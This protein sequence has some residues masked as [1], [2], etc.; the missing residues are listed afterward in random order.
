MRPLVL[1]ERWAV[2]EWA[3]GCVI[4]DRHTGDTHALDALCT[5]ILA[6]TPA[7][8]YDAPCAAAALAAAL[9]LPDEAGWPA[10]VG[11]ALDHLHRLELI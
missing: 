4:Y 1:S 6:L 5:E 7:A 8:R 11:E 2:R 3:D 10:R 9:E